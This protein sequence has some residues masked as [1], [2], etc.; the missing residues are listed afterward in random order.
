MPGIVVRGD[1]GSLL[2]LNAFANGPY[3]GGT[4]GAG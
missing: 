1:L 3:V 2:E 4:D